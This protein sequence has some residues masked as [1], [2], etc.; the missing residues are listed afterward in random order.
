MKLILILEIEWFLYTWLQLD[1]IAFGICK[2]NASDAILKQ[3]KIRKIGWKSNF[4][5]REWDEFWI[6]EMLFLGIA[7]VLV[8][9]KLKLFD[10]G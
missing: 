5:S 10:F 4:F 2:R 9:A 1:P 3:T 7:N 8:K 6:L